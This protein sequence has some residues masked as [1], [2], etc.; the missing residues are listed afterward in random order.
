MLRTASTR[1]LLRSLQTTSLPRHPYRIANPRNQVKAQL[2]S[3]GRNFSLTTVG[4]RSIALRQAPR[5]SITLRGTAQLGTTWVRHKSD[6][7]K[8]PDGK[9]PLK[10]T[11]DPDLITEDSSTVPIV[12]AGEQDESAQKQTDAAMASG[13]RSD[14]VCSISLTRAGRQIISSWSLICFVEHHS[15]DIRSR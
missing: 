1:P 9:P 14:L 15:R 8:Y 7:T 6:T 3:N 2:A 10:P 11:L 12:S 5:I 4:P 13:I